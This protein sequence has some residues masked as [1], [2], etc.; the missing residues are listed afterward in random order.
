MCSVVWC[1][2]KHHALAPTNQ[3]HTTETP[4]TF[5]GQLV[6]CWSDNCQA[7]QL[8]GAVFLVTQYRCPLPRDIPCDL[9]DSFVWFARYCIDCHV[10]TLSCLF[11]FRGAPCP[12]CMCYRSIP[13]YI[14]SISIRPYTEL[15]S[16]HRTLHRVAFVFL[17]LDSFPDS[18]DT[19]QTLF[20]PRRPASR[21]S[22]SLRPYVRTTSDPAA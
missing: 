7:L 20:R 6:L 1:V 8:L 5:D 9:L 2:K 3:P 10:S 19:F 11:S 17:Q 18:Y 4:G 16:L 21:L 12:L 22:P 13:R 14:S 15:S